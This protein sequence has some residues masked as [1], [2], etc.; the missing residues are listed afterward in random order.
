MDFTPV[1]HE[2]VKQLWWLIPLILIGAV[3]KS[4]RFKGVFGEW[5][6]RLVSR[7]GLPR[8]A[9]HRIDNISLP[10]ADGTTQI[11]HVLV[12]R[13]GVFVVETKNMQGWIFGSERQ[14]QWTQKIYKKTVKFQN[15]LRQNYKHVRALVELGIPEETLHSVVVFVGDSTFKT[16]MPAN[17]CSIR[18]YL[19]FV[20]S[21]HSAVLAESQV[22]EFVS[23]IERARLAPTRETH[24]AHVSAL[25]GK[26]SEEVE[27]RCPR[28]GALMVMRT[29][30]RGARKGQQFLGCSTYPACRAVKNISPTD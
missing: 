28:C 29:A 18:G 4:A 14:P 5:L 6:I 2:T 1:I 20:K 25:K 13:F 23:R 22:S 8:D 26:S 16:K 30:K 3:L 7:Y 10:T 19:R 27:P 12:S 15:P 17:V 24:Q 21:F 11:D 9:Y